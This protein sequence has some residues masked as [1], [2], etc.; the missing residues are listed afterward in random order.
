MCQAGGRYDGTSFAQVASGQ[1]RM[2]LQECPR[3]I[4][5]QG[6]SYA[7]HLQTVGQPVVDEY[8][9]REREHLRFVLQTSERCR[10]YKTV[11]IA[12]EFRAVVFPDLVIFSNP[13]RLLD[14]SCCQFIFI[15]VDSSQK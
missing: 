12:L 15:P 9:S 14:I 3:N 5:A 1:L 2:L 6:T 7:G 11:I 13:S 10:E 4:V 8:A